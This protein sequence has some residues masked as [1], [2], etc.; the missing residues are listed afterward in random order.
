MNWW[1]RTTN[2]ETVILLGA[3]RT[4]YVAIHSNLAIPP[5]VSLLVAYHMRS[6]SVVW[7]APHADG[8][9]L[10]RRFCPPYTSAR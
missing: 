7:P 4:D 3:Y 2:E 5:A 6:A 8:S 9:L 10:H 1:T